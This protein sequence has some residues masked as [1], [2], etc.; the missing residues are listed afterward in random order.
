MRFFSRGFTLNEILVVCAIIGLFSSVVIFSV[1]EARE[2]ARVKAE[3]AILEQMKL[4]LVLYRQM[5]DTF[6]PGTNGTLVDDCGIC[7][8]ASGADEN[9]DVIATALEAA[10]KTTRAEDSWGNPYGYD[11]NFRVSNSALY[12]ILCSMGPDGELQTFLTSSERTTDY[13]LTVANPQ[14]KGDDLCVFVR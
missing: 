8:L 3:L 7:L 11:N 5:H 13:A 12:T 2:K 9:W 6:P 10:V 1:S 4:E 14:P